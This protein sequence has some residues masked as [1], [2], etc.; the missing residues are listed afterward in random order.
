MNKIWSQNEFP[1]LINVY[2]FFFL[3][4]VVFFRSIKMSCTNN[5]I[6]LKP[7]FTFNQQEINSI[8][9]RIYENHPYCFQRQTPQCRGTRDESRLCFVLKQHKLNEFGKQLKYEFDGFFGTPPLPPPGGTVQVITS[10]PRIDDFFSFPFRMKP[11][12]CR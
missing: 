11:C 9:Q 2:I 1:K 3:E 7:S 5:V 4:F 6:L 8:S 12:D 10:T